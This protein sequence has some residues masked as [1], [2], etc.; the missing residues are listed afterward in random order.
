VRFDA[1]R[2]LE[3]SGRHAALFRQGASW[4]LRDLGSSNGTLVNGK[5]IKGDQQ[6]HSDDVIRFGPRGPE[7]R[8]VIR[9]EGSRTIPPTRIGAAAEASPA[10]PTETTER[11]AA[12]S[13]TQRIRAEVSRQ[14]APWRLAMIGLGILIGLGGLGIA[15]GLNRRARALERDRALLLARTDTLLHRLDSA[16]S[17]VLAL[18]AALASAREE[19]RTLRTSLTERA[20]TAERLD[21][22]AH[23]LQASVSRHEPV[24][25][26]A[27]LDVAGIARENGDAVGLIVSEFPGGRRI[28]GSGFAVRSRGDTGWI[29]TSRHLVLDPGGGRAS[30]L[31]VIFNGSGQNFRAEV[32]ATADS[33]DLALLVTRIRGGVPVVR[34]LGASPAPAAA[35]A[36][37]GFPFG[38]DF[39]VGDAWRKQGVSL[40]RFA[41]TVQAVR[42]D[43]LEVDAYGTGGSSGSPV[44][45]GAGEVV[46]VVY[47]G[48]PRTSGRI[49]YAVPVSRLQE[50]LKQAARF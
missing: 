6:L 20:L 15:F 23:R 47:G 41:G 45:N 21:S 42:S 27:Q 8:F 4:M 28:A 39:P 33:A 17:N 16:S 1:E 3:V 44:F 32:A 5:P 38:L 18:A 10:P 14:T 7:L 49:V 43:A 35:V 48:D 12:P 36:I 34:G 13:T 24:L 46:G 11:R 50:F 29:V 37:L 31:G 26:A 25:Q 30:R 19:T 22:L 9:E 2:D 40:S